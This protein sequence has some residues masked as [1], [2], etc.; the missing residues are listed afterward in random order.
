MLSTLLRRTDHYGCVAACGLVGGTEL[1]ISVHP[2]ILR[3]VTLSGIS[4]AWTPRP[5]RE[6]IWRRLASDWKL[7]I[8]AEAVRSVGLEEVAEEVERILAGQMTGRVVVE[9]QR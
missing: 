7:D 2:F 9:S 3:G 1:P 5:R 8:P 4:T 6:E